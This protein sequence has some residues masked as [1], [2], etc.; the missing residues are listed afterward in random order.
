MTPTG[1]VL[2]H[3][4]DSG[5]ELAGY[6]RMAED[7]GFDSLWVTERY[8]HE[9]TSSML[10]YLAATTEQIRLG[11]G[12]VNPFT[13][14][15]A[16]LGMGAATL[17]RLSSGRMM[18]GLGRSDFD[19]IHG[20]WPTLAAY[21]SPFTQTP[22]VLTYAYIEQALHDYYR[23]NF[24]NVHPVCI[25]RR[26]AENLGE[27][28]LPVVPNGIDVDAT[29]FGAEGEDFLVIVGRIAPNKGIAD[30][31]RIAKAAGERLV[32]VGHAP[33][34]L[35]WA[36]RYYREEVEPHVDGDRVRHAPHLPNDEVLKLVSR[37]KGF[38]FPLQWEEPF[39]LAVAEAL[40]VGTPVIAYPKGAMPEV[41]ADGRT[42]FLVESESEAARAIARLGE[43][44]RRACRAWVE[45]KFPISRMVEGYE[46]VYQA[47]TAG[48]A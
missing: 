29:P 5:P 21:F 36:E 34:Q 14:S 9:E 45:E 25:S 10:G 8:F 1:I 17:D 31:I 13:R 44:D 47:V 33:P 46:A 40:A 39:G 37:A 35:P 12:V 30:A 2:Y 15:P 26:Q 41:L 16:L 28:D 23:A 22:T 32:I 3:G 19:V 18:L 7:A 42:G 27:P 20:H 43:I 11:V 38:L 4:I 48:S 6:G 24:P